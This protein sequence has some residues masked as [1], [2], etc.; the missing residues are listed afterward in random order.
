M[1]ETSDFAAR[2]EEYRRSLEEK[3]TP[4]HPEEPTDNSFEGTDPSEI[5]SPH[6]LPATKEFLQ[7]MG[8]RFLPR[9]PLG[10][11]A[12]DFFTNKLISED[13]LKVTGYPVGMGIFDDRLSKR[14]V[15]RW[16]EGISR[17]TIVHLCT[18]GLLRARA[19]TIE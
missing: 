13:R 17:S 10:S 4:Q 11:K 15:I 12:E 6:S 5:F 14:P 8:G 1:S 16:H 7:Y 19:S 18:D 2:V 3:H 9:F